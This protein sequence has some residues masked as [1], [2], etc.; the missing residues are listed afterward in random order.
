MRRNPDLITLVRDD[1]ER[2]IRAWN[3]SAIAACERRCCTPA[4]RLARLTR[5]SRPTPVDC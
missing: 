1:R 4:G 5:A 3:L 2:E